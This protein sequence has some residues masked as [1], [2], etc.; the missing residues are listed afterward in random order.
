[1]GGWGN[2]LSAGTKEARSYDSVPESCRSNHSITLNQRFDPMPRICAGPT[3]SRLGG[4]KSRRRTDPQ[5]RD[6]SL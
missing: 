3:R 4:R 1:M 2:Q 6:W 5:P